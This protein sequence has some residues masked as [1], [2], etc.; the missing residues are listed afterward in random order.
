MPAW[1]STWLLGRNFGS[2]AGDKRDGILL[3]L[4]C[5]TYLLASV[6]MTCLSA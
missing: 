2:V 3:S 1:G 5:V 4:E 6:L